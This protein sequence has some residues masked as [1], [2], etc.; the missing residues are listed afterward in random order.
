MDANSDNTARSLAGAFERELFASAIESVIPLLELCRCCADWYA[1]RVSGRGR[2]RDSHGA[3]GACVCV[4]LCVCVCVCFNEEYRDTE[5][6][7]AGTVCVR[8]FNLLDMF[9]FNVPTAINATT[10]HI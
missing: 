3:Q 1:G 7:R 2:A 6:E 5:H 8:V 10:L 9:A 4:C